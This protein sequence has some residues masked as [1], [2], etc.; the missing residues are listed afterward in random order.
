M[1]EQF[2]AW[3]VTSL[4]TEVGGGLV[5]VSLLGTAAYV[6][7]TVPQHLFQLI[8]RGFTTELTVRSDDQMFLIV[9][10][11][12]SQQDFIG[13]S[14]RLK[15]ISKSECSSSPQPKEATD[16]TQPEFVL[17][18]APGWHYFWYG[19]RP[20]L[21]RIDDGQENKTERKGFM[22]IENISMR[23]IGRNGSVFQPIINDALNAVKA[24]RRINVN[25]HG[26]YGWHNARRKLPR[27]LSTVITRDNIGSDILNDMATFFDSREWYV[28]RGIPWR[29]GY[30]LTG[31]PGTG[32]SSLVFALASELS[33]PIYSLSLGVQLDD[34]QL[35]SLL[36]DVPERS[37]L[38]IEDID[39][40]SITKP[41][42][43][44]VDGEKKELVTLSG[45]LNALDGVT[46]GEGRV[47]VMT[48]NHPDKLDS[49]LTRAGRIDRTV[50]LSYFTKQEC[51]K[52]WRM[53][54]DDENA[55]GV[56]CHQLFDRDIQ[57][58]RLQEHLVQYQND[59]D[60]AAYKAI[61]LA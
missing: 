25:I 43:V 40:F 15:L 17:V 41:R 6:L 57:P 33:I 47:V 16:E 19:R 42:T 13:H 50:E 58:A 5:A 54:F 3:M 9:A 24:E 18:P 55:A 45:L 14:R 29:R 22:I 23:T 46:A 37:I 32:K 12:L 53:F 51:L 26:E 28:K 52:M 44:E 31:P 35:T 34:G 10:R 2:V 38:L 61:E 59:P 30:M 11:W 4:Q 7:R 36:M 21:L 27:P 39:A 48:T 56:F 60:L 8:K 20:V 49:A 1:I